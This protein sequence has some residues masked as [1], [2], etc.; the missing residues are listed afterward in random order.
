MFHPSKSID[1]KEKVKYEGK[2]ER[3]YHDSGKIEK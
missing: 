1:R 3:T 2:I